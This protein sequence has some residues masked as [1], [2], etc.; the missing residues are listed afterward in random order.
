MNDTPL[1]DAPGEAHRLIAKALAELVADDPAVPPHPYISRHL[2]DH[3]ARGDVLD[4]DHVPPALLPWESGNNVRA[5]L[6]RSGPGDHQEW[7]RAWARIEPFARDADPESR[8]TSL[9]LAHFAA[10]GRRVPL[11]ARPG[12]RGRTPGSRI[13][14]LWSDWT[15][16][17]NVL[18]VC[19]VPVESLACLTTADG[20]TLLAGGDSEGTIRRWERHGV[21]FGTPLR[22]GG[23]AIRHLLPLGDGRLVSG[24]ADGAVRLWHGERGLPLAAPVHRPHTWVSALALHTPPQSP[25]CVVVAYG[26]GALVALDAVRLAPVDIALPLPAADG[27]PVVVAAVACEGQEGQE[28]QEGC[29]RPERPER[30]ERWEGT[31]GQG[32][33]LVLA[34]GR[35]VTLHRPGRKPV[36][37][38]EHRDEVRAVVP[39]TT[40]GRFATCDDSG[41][42]RIWDAAAGRETA[43]AAQSP[44]GAVIAVAPVTVD[45]REAVVAAGIDHTL[46]VWD[47]ATG[48]PVGAPLAGHTAPPVA[49]AALPGATDAYIVSASGDGTLRRW[50]L[51]GHGSRPRP[52]LRRPVT[53]AALPGREIAGPGLLV[54]VADRTGATLWDAETG[55][56]RPLPV[57]KSP[58]TA[59]A[60]AAAVRPDEGPLLA[61]AHTDSA[62]RLWSLDAGGGTRAPVPAGE[63]LRHSLP[64]QAMVAFPADDRSLLATAGADGWVC[65]W[66]LAGRELLRRWTGHRLSVRDVTVLTGA[67]GTLVVSAGADGA[68]RF[69]DP[70]AGAS[71]AGPVVHCG[72]RGVHALAVV[73]PGDGE[74]ALLASGG[75]DG[76]VR[77]WDAVT[78]APSG[79]AL[80]AA[81]GPVT[82]LVAFR[83]PAGRTVLAA[84]GPGGTVQLWDVAARRPLLRLVTGNPLSVLAVR[85]D[86]GAPSGHDGTP[87]LLAAGQAG[88]CVLGVHLERG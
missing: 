74:G 28:G 78:L 46:R 58:V 32:T 79:D 17:D 18:A 34:Q 69:W 12:A 76:T 66:D 80:D 37:L 13:T 86:D 57:R 85:W 11:A 59:F 6:R 36:H 42:V 60:W 83:T 77:L 15:A 19:G 41:A 10:S 4:D 30:P 72:Q 88:V 54:A 61:T 64:V 39:L 50:R 70:A 52:P 56:G 48:S 55:R 31:E 53:A 23:G 40:P 71:A 33:A 2:A 82:A 73:E 14:P 21:P 25:P 44:A 9:Q 24:G 5:L 75:E 38:A 7:L 51:A 63:L 1:W 27:A 26:D 65:L 45:G 87:V 67:G 8:L 3:A 81:D 20:R 84:A 29:E 16:Q 35:R 62:V 22:T 43:A 68:L 49:L 47:A